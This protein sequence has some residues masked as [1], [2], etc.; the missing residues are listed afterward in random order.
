MDYQQREALKQK[1]TIA[2][3]GFVAGALAW[4][5]VL[6]SGFGWVSAGTAQQRTSDAVQTKV[7][8][9]LAPF[10]ADRFMA[11]KAALAKFVKAKEDYDRA[12]IVQKAIPKIGAT[13]VDYQ[14]SDACANAIHA[15]L[16]SASS[17][18][19]KIPKKS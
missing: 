4:W 15:R 6:A 14:L 19:A 8:Q 11:D 5:L 1:V 12:Q 3:V 7:D 17:N 18:G 9:V 2:S 10:C 16:K 13:E